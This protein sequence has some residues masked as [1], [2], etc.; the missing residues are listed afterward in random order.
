MN[1]RI[2]YIEYYNNGYFRGSLGDAIVVNFP[3]EV[4]FIPYWRK[5]KIVYSYFR[6]SC[7]GYFDELK[8]I[9]LNDIVIG[10]SLFKC[11]DF[12]FGYTQLYGPGFKDKERKIEYLPYEEERLGMS[13]QL[14]LGGWHSSKDKFAES[15]KYYGLVSWI[16]KELDEAKL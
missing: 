2:E 13:I 1:K 8:N 11:L 3:I 7:W 4:Y 15:E 9:I 5:N 14:Y 10:I 6:W 12:R 16:S